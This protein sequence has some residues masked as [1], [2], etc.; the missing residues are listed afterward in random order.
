VNGAMLEL[1]D[2]VKDRIRE[3]QR[4]E[5]RVEEGEEGARREL[6]RAVREST[7]TV[8]ARCA[9]V[10]GKSRGMLSEAVSGGSPL[11]KEALEAKAEAMRT[12][13]AGED[14]TPL[15]L[16]LASDITNLWLVVEML[17]AFYAGQ[18]QRR[19][20]KG[21]REHKGAT[22]SGIG[23]LLKMQE[24]AHRRYLAAVRELAHVRKLQAGAPAVQV[25]TQVNILGS[26]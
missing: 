13:I 6:R 17:G 8:I 26:G 20:R 1:S 15:E 24:S 5:K 14:P 16:L 12:E 23:F 9:D 10:S 2:A 4:L 7:P 25:N 19:E 11:I 22:V 18:F 3:L 21:E